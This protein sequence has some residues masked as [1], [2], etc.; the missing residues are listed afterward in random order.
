[1][2]LLM[3][4][5]AAMNVQSTEPASEASP[6]PLPQM[7]VV[8]E[9]DVISEEAPPHGNIG[10]STAYRISDA[11]PRREMEF[12]K[13]TLHPGAAVGVHPIGHDEV[14]YVTEGKGRVTSDG[15]S[16]ILTVGMAAYLYAGA[17]VGIEQ[18]GDE[19]LTIIISY[20]LEMRRAE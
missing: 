10:M 13:R 7:V 14:Y 19:P 12:R 9:K 2:T 20:P 6:A 17:E 16:A 18:L 11:A 5:V 4:L 3:L 8:D 15:E 1:M